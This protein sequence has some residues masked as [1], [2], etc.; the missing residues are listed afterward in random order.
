MDVFTWGGGWWIFLPGGGG[1]AGAFRFFLLR[2]VV[3]SAMGSGRSAFVVVV[4]VLCT[5]SELSMEEASMLVLVFALSCVLVDSR[6]EFPG[7]SSGDMLASSK[8]LEC[9]LFR[10]WWS[11]LC[12]WLVT[13]TVNDS[14]AAE[15]PAPA[16]PG[17]GGGAGA[18]RFVLGGLFGI[19]ALGAAVAPAPDAW[20]PP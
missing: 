12:W 10:E 15:A 5:M 14:D 9:E 2:E 6:E 20:I 17:G 4:V 7:D 1:G 19:L 3:P 16:A 18:F 8:P 13:D 11:L